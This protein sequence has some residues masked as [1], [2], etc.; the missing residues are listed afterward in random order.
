MGAAVGT[1]KSRTLIIFPGALGDLICFIPALRA[2]GERHPGA[3]LELMAR[4]E[5]ARFAVGRTPIVRAHSIDRAEVARLFAVTSEDAGAG[6]AF[7][8]SFERI[9]SFFAADNDRFRR[10]LAALA[11]DVNFYPFRPLD[12]GHVAAGYLRS[13]DAPV[14]PSLVAHI[15]LLPDDIAAATAILA[16]A[17]LE[18][19]SFMLILPG[20]GSRAKNWPPANF[21][22]LAQLL[23]PRT[24]SLC[25]LGPAEAEL[26]D[27]FRAAGIPS[28]DGLEL[29]VVAA[30][31]ARARVFVGNDSGVAHLAAA[32]GAPGVVL[33]GPTDPQRWC[34][35]GAVRTLQDESMT[36]MT[37]DEVAAAIAVCQS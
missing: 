35:L 37:V 28:I 34:P 10:S 4:F 3:A 12:N 7:F 15:D 30:L 13:L 29:G 18:P 33:F 21:V 32:A 17:G 8:S 27:V 19:R 24:R 31:A 36:K 5:L 26:G 11:H 6:R 1:S 23:T 22:A 2:I 14:G 16:R 25:V 9:Y 20:S